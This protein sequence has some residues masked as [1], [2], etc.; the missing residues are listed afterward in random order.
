MSPAS[1]LRLARPRQWLKNGFVLVGIVFGH[2]W[3]DPALVGAVLMLF[4]A[5]C[6][7]SSAAY[8]LNDVMDREADRRHPEKRYRE[9]ASGRIRVR[10]A[11]A[12]AAVLALG[13]LALAW[14]VSS[15]ALG[16]G[17]GYAVI[18]L[19]YS[20][21]MKHVAVLDVFLIAAGFML[22]ILAGTLGVGIE[23]S[24]WLLLCGLMLT[25]FLGFAKRRAELAA[26]SNRAREQGA[27]GADLEENAA[28]GNSASHRAAETS[29][30]P[31]LAAYS[32]ELLD[33]TIAVSAAGAAISYAFYTID[34]HTIETHGTD[35]LVATVP[36]VLYGVYRYLWLLYRRGGCLDPAAEVLRDPHLLGVLLGWLALTWWLIA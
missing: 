32:L 11:L 29:T 6:M 3:S 24:R 7:L 2:G 36:L 15:A 5:F 9:V 20:F 34:A 18:N 21:G 27:L 26:L 8:A 14:T 17:A 12:S 16:L 13:G 19:A 31:A 23:P 25:L 4:A 1:Y 30:R 28:E 22:R 33:R 35:K 10:F